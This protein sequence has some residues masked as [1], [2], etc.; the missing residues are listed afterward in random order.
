MSRTRY[1][2]CCRLGCEELV[3]DRRRFRNPSALWLVLVALQA[4]NAHINRAHPALL[5]G[6]AAAPSKANK[7]ASSRAQQQ[8]QAKESGGDAPGGSNS[9]Q[10]SN[11]RRKNRVSEAR[12]GAAAAA[13][14]DAAEFT[15]AASASPTVISHDADGPS[16]A[17]GAGAASVLKHA[18]ELPGWRW[19]LA[20]WR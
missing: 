9:R 4:W 1:T 2:A 19:E 5:G 8:Q 17:R 12:A 15:A 10:R 20:G 7:P 18:G 16:H 14:A 3:V 13:A 11:S 6:F